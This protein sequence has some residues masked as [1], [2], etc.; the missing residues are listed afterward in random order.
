M[1]ARDEPGRV[2]DGYARLYGPIAVA[3]LGLVFMP[4]FDDQ[5]VDLA[6]GTIDRSFGTLWETAAR[7][8]GGPAV[9]GIVLA[10]VLMTLCLVATFRPRSA[11]TPAGIAVVCVPVIVML[12]TKPRAGDP[13]PD[14]SAA[15]S[16]ALAVVVFTAVLATTHAAHYA[17]WSRTQAPSAVASS[18]A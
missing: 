16:A 3:A 2:F 14:L 1:T 12:I 11:G 13:A 17:R 15:G 7:V 9:L 6:D 18:P 8:N 4:I 10:L 5:R